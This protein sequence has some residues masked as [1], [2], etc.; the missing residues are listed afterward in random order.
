VPRESILQLLKCWYLDRFS[1]VGGRPWGLNSSYCLSKASLSLPRVGITVT[2]LT[3]RFILE[4]GL[5]EVAI[6]TC[7]E[8]KVH[9]RVTEL[10]SFERLRLQLLKLL[11]V[12]IRMVAIFCISAFDAP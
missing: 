12:S 10:Q 9:G 11:A 1:Q 3:R 6:F 7:H 2:S 4:G 8:A 5:L